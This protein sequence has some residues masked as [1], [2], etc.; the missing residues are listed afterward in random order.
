MPEFPAK[1][2]ILSD[3]RQAGKV[4]RRINKKIICSI[5]I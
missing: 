1:W 2:A 5:F 3:I 4:K